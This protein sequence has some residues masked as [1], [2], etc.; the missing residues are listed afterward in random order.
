MV[1]T[2]EGHA[3]KL[4]LGHLLDTTVIV[5][6]GRLHYYEGYSMEEIIYPVRL[7]RLLGIEY[8]IITSAAGA[9]NPRYRP[10]DIVLI[11]DHINAMGE[12]CLRGAHLP[13]FGERFPDMTDIYKKDLRKTLLALARRDRITAHEGVYLAMSGPSYET[14]A[15]IAAFRKMGAD[16]IGMSVV[17]EA[18]AANQM[19]VKVAAISYVSNLSAGVTRRT[20]LSHREVLETGKMVN[21]KL[22]RL[23]LDAVEKIDSKR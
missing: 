2:I 20:T 6:R 8:L 21:R 3:G 13:Q 1:P 4:M 15:E 17:P 9:V 7:M 12:N 16:I 14:P 23:L 22:G 18:M 11:R 19:G 5:M 10:G